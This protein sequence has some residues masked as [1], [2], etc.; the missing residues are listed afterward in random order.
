MCLKPGKAADLQGLTGE[1]IRV[2]AQVPDGQEEGYICQPF[3]ECM[4]WLL[5]RLFDGEAMPAPM[6]VSKL[7][8]VPKAGQVTAPHDHNMYRGI[9]VS[10]VVA[11][12]WDRVLQGQ[13]D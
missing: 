2:A 6:C 12:V 4:R 8:P 3:V 11:R 10:S 5:Q 1:A 7:T 13:L 9:C